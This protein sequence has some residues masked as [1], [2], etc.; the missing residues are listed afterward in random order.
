[1]NPTPTQPTRPGA[2]SNVGTGIAGEVE[3][4]MQKMAAANSQTSGLSLPPGGSNQMN[5]SNLNKLAE[6]CA[7]NGEYQH[8]I[9]YYLQ[10][11]NLDPDNGPAWTALGHCY[12]LIEDL[13]KSFN[14]YQHALYSL[15]DIKDP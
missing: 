9:E 5:V 11:T 12:L 6:Y 15:E 13:Q 1:M 10:L 8:A 4:T 2:G 14:A 7:T 3:K